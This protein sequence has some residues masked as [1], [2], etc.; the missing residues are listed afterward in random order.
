MTLSVDNFVASTGSSGSGQGLLNEPLKLDGILF[1]GK[2][3]STTE[4]EN[5]TK[6]SAKVSENHIII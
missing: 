2:C 5:L 4:K 3:Q 1:L 6:I